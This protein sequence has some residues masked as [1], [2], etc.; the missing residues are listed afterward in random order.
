MIAI[1]GAGPTGLACGIELKKRGIDAVLFDK[2]CVV[3]SLYH[4]PT[5]MVF[6][7]TPE[8]LEIGGIPM[9]SIGEKPVRVEVA[10][11]EAD[12]PR[13]T[14]P[15]LRHRHQLLEVV[16]KH[17]VYVRLVLVRGTGVRVAHHEGRVV[18]LMRVT[19]LPEGRHL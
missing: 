7:T 17:H 9:T 11:E 8:L 19:V 10:L 4:Y 18:V 13:Q 12:L 5:N 14:L 2:G 3:N 6:F 1:V 16:P 15:V